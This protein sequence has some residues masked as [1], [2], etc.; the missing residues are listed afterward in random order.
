MTRITPGELEVSAYYRMHLGA[1]N[2]AAGLRIQFHY[3]QVPGVHFRAEAP[4]EFKAAILRGIGDGMSLRFPSFPE[5]GSIWILDVVVDDV[6]SSERAF[7][8]AARM[9]IDQ[10]FSLGSTLET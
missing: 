5:S 8:R 6:D 10:A 9:V 3:N 7:Y 2:E 4:D 1:R